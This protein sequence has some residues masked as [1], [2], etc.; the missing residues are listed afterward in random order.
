M[1]ETFNEVRRLMKQ[2]DVI[3]R[4][5]RRGIGLCMYGLWML[6]PKGWEKTPR[7]WLHVLSHAP[8]IKEGNAANG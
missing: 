7:A 8:L 5:E 6:I 4:Q 3:A 2:H 1:A